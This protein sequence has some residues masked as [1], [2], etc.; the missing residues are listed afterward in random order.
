LQPD[1][2]RRTARPGW[3]PTVAALATV[4]L[5]VA[6][7]NWQH[8][9]M[10]EKE[11]L[12][13]SMQQSGSIAPVPLPATV[14]DWSAWRFRQVTVTGEYDARHQ[15]LID[16]KVQAGHVG[17]DVVTPLRLSD[18]R[19]VLVDRGWIGAGRSRATLPQSPPPAGTVTVSGR[20]DVPRRNYFELGTA[21]VPAGPLW[22]HLDPARFTRATGIDVLPIVVDA[23]D[24]TS[25]AGLVADFPMPDAGVDTHLGYMVQWYTFAAM[26]AGL[27]A[28]F[29]LRPRFRARTQASR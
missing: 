6:A 25:S 19:T 2:P 22:Q 12:Q 3:V 14:D 20:I 16:N 1:E 27:W 13:E 26:A 23:T 28:W 9:R 7:G 11:A 21:G 24:A 8:R 17:F 15:I 18:G 5:C 4:V 10:L 29:T